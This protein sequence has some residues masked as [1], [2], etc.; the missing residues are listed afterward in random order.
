MRCREGGHDRSLF[1]TVFCVPFLHH[2]FLSIPTLSEITI[3]NSRQRIS[4]SLNLVRNELETGNKLN[5]FFNTAIYITITIANSV[6]FVSWLSSHIKTCWAHTGEKS[7]VFMNAEVIGRIDM[8]WVCY[9]SFEESNS[10][11]TYKT[12][13]DQSQQTSLALRTFSRV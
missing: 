9:V 13:S 1:Q 6:H 12:D 4:P 10:E 5:K 8:I 2:I 3:L 11:Q 7:N